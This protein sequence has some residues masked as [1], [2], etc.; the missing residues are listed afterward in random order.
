[1]STTLLATFSSPNL[2]FQLLSNN[3]KTVMAMAENDK[4]FIVLATEIKMIL[5]HN[6]DTEVVLDH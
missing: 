5:V 3:L 2:A 1:M 4:G 6:L